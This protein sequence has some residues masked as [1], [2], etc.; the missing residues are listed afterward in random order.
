MEQNVRSNSL[1]DDDRQYLEMMQGNIERMAGNC[2]NCKA[3]LVTIISALM[4]L[5]FSIDALSWGVLLSML[6]ILLFWYLNVYYLH[7]ERGM[8]NR[9]T[10]FLNLFRNNRLEGYEEALFNFEPYMIKKKDLTE[11]KKQQGLVATNDRWLTKSVILFYGITFVAVILISVVL[12]W[13]TIC[14]LFANGQD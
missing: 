8:R 5:L 1:N 9:E 4:A 2:A 12:N 7:L 10:A 14:G 13:T 3:W 11:A 6:P